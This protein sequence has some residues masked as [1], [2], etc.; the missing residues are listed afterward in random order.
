MKIKAG[1]FDRIPSRYSE[2]LQRVIQWMLSQE[3]SKRP[4]VDDLMRLPQMSLR[5]REKKLQE[6]MSRVK[7]R[8]D[9][10]IVKEAKVAERENDVKK[11]EEEVNKKE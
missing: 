10:V 1:T 8:E 7:R 3:S 9:E 11:R 5:M 2:E 4:T 6:N